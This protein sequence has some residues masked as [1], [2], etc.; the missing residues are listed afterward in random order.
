[1]NRIFDYEGYPVDPHT[2]SND[3]FWFYVGKSGLTLACANAT[4]TV[5]WQQIKKALKDREA[6]PKRRRRLKFPR[7]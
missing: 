7:G 1:M 6:A 4:A 3:H 5:S 2:T